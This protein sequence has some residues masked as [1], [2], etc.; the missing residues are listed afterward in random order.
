MSRRGKVEDLAWF[1][2]EGRTLA[3][4]CVKS[5]KGDPDKC[6]PEFGWVTRDGTGF[7]VNVRDLETDAITEVRP[8][9]TIETLFDDWEVD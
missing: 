4:F 9:A 1:Y 3:V 7:E 6:V 2:S 8:Y 5:Y